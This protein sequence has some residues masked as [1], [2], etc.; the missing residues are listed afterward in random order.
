VDVVVSI[1]IFEVSLF[2]WCSY[3]Q[4]FMGE[5]APFDNYSLSH[6]I[7]NKCEQ[8][9]LVS[10]ADLPDKTLE[11]KELMNQLFSAFQNEDPLDCRNLVREAQDAGIGRAEILLGMIQ[12]ALYQIGELWK[13][14]KITSSQEHLFTSW[15]EQIYA[16]LAGFNSAVSNDKHA[17]L[18]DMGELLISA[19][20][21]E[22][23]GIRE[24]V[25]SMEKW[26]ADSSCFSPAWIAAV[27]T[28][29]ERAR[30]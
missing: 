16:L 7:C 5:S 3:C 1:L 10:D 24:A 20:A 12:P 8:E 13:T 4:S 26:V 18:S 19:V 11:A 23:A 14:A 6:G 27:R 25:S 28:L 9:V 15:C 29:I 17:C 2:R 22:K 30:R 21:D